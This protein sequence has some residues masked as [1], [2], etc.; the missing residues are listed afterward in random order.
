MLE[1]ALDGKQENWPMPAGTQWLSHTF[2]TVRH[3]SG[4]FSDYQKYSL[5][6][7]A[8]HELKEL[9]GG[10]QAYATAIKEFEMEHGHK[11]GD[12]RAALPL[13]EARLKGS[14]LEHWTCDD[15][16]RWEVQDWFDVVHKMTE[17]FSGVNNPRT[18]N[19]LR[20]FF[21]EHQSLVSRAIEKADEN[22]FAPHLVSENPI[23]ISRYYSP[24]DNEREHKAFEE[25][26]GKSID[27]INFDE[28]EDIS[29]DASLS[30]LRTVPRFSE[31]VKTARREWALLEPLLGKVRS[32]HKFYSDEEEYVARRT[33][34]LLG[35]PIQLAPY[36]FTRAHLDG[37]LNQSV[38]M[39]IDC[40]A[41][42]AF[43][44]VNRIS[45]GSDLVRRKIRDTL[46]NH[47]W[48]TAE[49][50]ERI[51]RER[52]TYYNDPDLYIRALNERL[53]RPLRLKPSK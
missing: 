4:S 40:D 11:P 41:L 12:F 34:S 52:A 23:N 48:V 45:G 3:L 5:L 28:D 49:E 39:G 46:E 47:Y 8:V 26:W 27:D 22:L 50:Y 29:P 35:S 2:D 36:E 1:N 38:I 13:L 7:Q 19:F 32:Y 18:P 31:A 17:Q 10:E 25:I 44:D 51:D 20:K 53:G 37:L 21:A 16:V 30:A 33:N 14:S 6:Q 42:L 15:R 9:K 43:V 24:Q